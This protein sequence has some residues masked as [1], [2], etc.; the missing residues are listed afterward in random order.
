MAISEG[1]AAFTGL[2]RFGSRAFRCLRRRTFG[3]IQSHRYAQEVL[4]GCQRNEE[5][6]WASLMEATLCIR[7]L[8]SG[9]RADGENRRMKRTLL[10]I[11]PGLGG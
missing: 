7:F 3:I 8:S 11:S 10:G 2:R 1:D 5:P 9:G 4:R 6:K